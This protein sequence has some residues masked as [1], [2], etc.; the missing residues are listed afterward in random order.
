MRINRLAE[1]RNDLDELI[2]LKPNEAPLLALRG[3]TEAGL[4]QLDLGMADVQQ[5]G[6][7]L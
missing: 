7:C 4:R 2:K 1:A 6:T 3:M 5:P